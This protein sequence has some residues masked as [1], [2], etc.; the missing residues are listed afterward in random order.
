LRKQSFFVF[1]V[2]CDH[3]MFKLRRVA[4]SAGHVRKAK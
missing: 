4:P 2:G 3:I 1:A